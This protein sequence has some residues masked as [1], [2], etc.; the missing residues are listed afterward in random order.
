MAKFGAFKFAVESRTSVTELKG[1]LAFYKFL[2][3]YM[4]E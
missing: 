4:E 3:L 2:V 1:Q